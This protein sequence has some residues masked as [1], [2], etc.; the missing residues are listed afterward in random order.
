MNHGYL[1]RAF[2]KIRCRTRSCR[3]WSTGCISGS[4][5]GTAGRLWF[6]EP[7]NKELGGLKAWRKPRS[8]YVPSKYS[9]P[10]PLQSPY[11]GPHKPSTNWHSARQSL[12]SAV[13]VGDGGPKNEHLIRNVNPRLA[14]SEDPAKNEL[15]IRDGVRDRTWIH[16]P[17]CLNGFELQSLAPYPRLWDFLE[18]NFGVGGTS[19]GKRSRVAERA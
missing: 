1:G 2:W 12:C 13:R 19:K 14:A 8:F 9:Y 11:A 10:L 17:R 15:G 5:K 3:A 16:L 4:R 7:S 6:S 18:R